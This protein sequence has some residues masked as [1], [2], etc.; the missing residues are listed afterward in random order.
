[1]LGLYQSRERE[2]LSPRSIFLVRYQAATPLDSVPKK[3]FRGDWVPLGAFPN[4]SI[5]DID[6]PI[7]MQVAA[8]RC[9]TKAIIC[10]ILH[11]IA[12][13]RLDAPM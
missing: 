2:G 12:L 7:P 8:T 5:K 4:P 3:R 10:N 13:S 11:M 1:M 6:S 9:T